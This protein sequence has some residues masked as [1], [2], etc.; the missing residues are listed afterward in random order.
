MNHLLA[1]AIAVAACSSAT[2]AEHPI[3]LAIAP[4]KVGEAC[5]ALD[6]GDTLAW[7]FKASRASDFNLHQHVG[8][9]VM[10]PIERKAVSE[11]AAEHKV[12]RANEWCLMWTA[13]ADK[14]PVTV[15]GAWQVKKAAAK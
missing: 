10:M 14:K 5:M 9:E 7:R 15:N 6:A 13:S 1:L 8:N 12:D 4:G 11:D 2:A 3:R